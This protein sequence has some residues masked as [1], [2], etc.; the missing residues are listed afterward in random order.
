MA[1]AG[2]VT[3]IH[4]PI[5]SATEGNRSG[6]YEARE[7]MPTDAPLTHPG[8]DPERATKANNRKLICNED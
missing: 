8:R 2:C 7:P 1:P 4:S 3:G 5:K 6:S